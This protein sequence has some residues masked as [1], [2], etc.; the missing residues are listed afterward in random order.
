MENT[1]GMHDVKNRFNCCRHRRF[2]LLNLCFC[3]F[4]TE[5]QF[6]FLRV[7][8]LPDSIIDS[9]PACEMAHSMFNNYLHRYSTVFAVSEV[10]IQASER[11]KK[12]QQQQQMNKSTSL[13]R[14]C[15][16]RCSA[17]ECEKAE[18]GLL[19]VGTQNPSVS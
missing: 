13:S 14:S 19:C 2:G 6:F 9:R 3:S 11:R 8:K 16:Q 4:R 7:A 12:Q 5:I 18:N 15:I 17:A 1:H 10:T